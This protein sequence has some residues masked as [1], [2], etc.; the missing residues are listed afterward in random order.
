MGGADSG[1]RADAVTTTPKDSESRIELTERLA[2]DRE[3]LARQYAGLAHYRGRIE[4]KQFN[5]GRLD[6]RLG[7]QR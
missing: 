6:E 3:I 7:G 1:R 4:N 2:R 5:L